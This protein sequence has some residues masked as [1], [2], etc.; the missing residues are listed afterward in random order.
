MDLAAGRS[1][2]SP[3]MTHGP[4]SQSEELGTDPAIGSLD[5]VDDFRWV[6]IRAP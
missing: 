6:P 3:G 5:D 2:S 4:L 1:Y